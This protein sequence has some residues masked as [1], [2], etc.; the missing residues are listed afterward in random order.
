MAQYKDIIIPSGSIFN[1]A[2][3]KGLGNV[4]FN[5]TPQN[6]FDMGVRVAPNGTYKITSIVDR[7][8]EDV[9]E[10]TKSMEISGFSVEIGTI[11]NIELT[12]D[13]IATIPTEPIIY[14]GNSYTPTMTT[15][16]NP[17]NSGNTTNQTKSATSTTMTPTKKGIIA[18]LVIGVIY[19][20]FNYKKIIK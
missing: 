5:D 8:N 1:N 16:A 9:T 4:S 14:S 18:L 12:K 7:S 20:L 13:V 15:N 19:A 6:E 3:I 2:T 10:F 17:S 11:V